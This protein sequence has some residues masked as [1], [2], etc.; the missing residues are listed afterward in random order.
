MQADGNILY[1][2]QII[3]IISIPR[4]KQKTWAMIPSNTTKLSLIYANKENSF[5][6]SLEEMRKTWL[7]S[8]TKYS[9]HNHQN[10]PVP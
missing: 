1:I 5:V 9:Q 4:K 7:R 6:W 3:S 8:N 2:F 10:Q